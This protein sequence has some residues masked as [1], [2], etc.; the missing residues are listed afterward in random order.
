MADP[1]GTDP[2]IAEARER[3][4]RCSEAEDA[5]R[6]RIV[7]AKKF[8]ADDQWPDA[9][10]IQREGQTSLQGVAAQPPRPCLTVDR[11]SA[12]VRQISNSIKSASFAIEVLPNGNGADN[13]VADIYQGYLRRVWNQAR[14]ESPVEWAADQAIEGGIGWFRLRTDYVLENGPESSETTQTAF[15]IA[16]FDQELR[17]ERITNNLTVYCDPS[18]MK[19]TRSDAAFM[20]VTEDLYKEEFERRYPNADVRGLEEFA[21]TGDLA[22]WVTKDMYRIAEYWKVRYDKA[23]YSMMPDGS[24]VEGEI[25]GAKATREVRKPIVKCYKINAHEILESYDWLGSRI[26]LIPILGEELNLDGRTILRGVIEQGMDAQRMVNYTYSAAMEIA[27]LGTKG[28]FI[29]AAG[30]IAQYTKQWD[31]RT[32]TNW[33]YLPYDPQSIGGEVAPPPHYEATEAPIS[34]FVELMQISEECVKATTGFYDPGLGNNNPREKSGRA[35]QAL[36][37]QSELGSSNYPNNVSRALIYAGELCVEIIPKLTRPGQI[38]HI[39]G[40]D[41]QPQPPVMVGQ[42]FTQQPKGM[43]I[44]TNQPGVK[45]DDQQIQQGLVKFYDLSKGRY[46]VTV[47]SGKADTTRREEGATALGALIPHLP[48]EM[49]AVATPE[50]VQQLAFPDSDRI[51]ERLRQT[52]PPQLQEQGDDASIPPQVKQQMAAMQQQLQQAQQIIETDQAKQQATIAKAKSDN[53]TKIQIAKFDQDFQVWKAQLDAQTKIAV[54]EISAKS[55]EADRQVALADTL[56]GLEKEQRLEQHDRTHEHVQNA[57]DRQHEKE[58]ADLEQRHALEQAAAGVAGDAGLAEQ[59]HGHATEQADQAHG[60]A[61]DQAQQ[62]SDLAPE[63]T[64]EP[65][66]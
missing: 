36:Q 29:V 3:W 5:Q 6:K 15:D 31:T 2:I 66:E 48:P 55:Q 1:V 34:A 17:L 8:R 13:E 30:Q 59:A 64:T 4:Q 49:A 52:L 35:I 45:P 12:P 14:G 42:A 33:S 63:P 10:R 22:T 46:S 50:Y 25:K 53:E 26:P 23:S 24:I 51:A 21:A 54:A 9:I 40:K 58:M 47:A 61:L 20:F 60:Q 38:L 32:T 41:A 57:L 37:G 27:A 39:L 19:P 16:I 43:P 18:A 56:I 62:A 44:P 65:A 7:A 11:L 28:T